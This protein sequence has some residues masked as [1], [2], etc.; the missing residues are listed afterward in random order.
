MSF[1]NLAAWARSNPI[2]VAS[3]VVT[4]A[5]IGVIV[6]TIL[7]AG[8]LR[9]EIEDRDNKFST[10]RQLMS[11]TIEVPSEDP[12]G[13]PQYLRN[14]AISQQ[15]IE[16]MRGIYDRMRQELEKVFERAENIN[17]PDREMLVAGL[18]PDADRTA[19]LPITA[20]FAYRQQVPR[21]L[22]E[23]E[24]QGGGARLDA[25]EPPTAQSV[26]RQIAEDVREFIRQYQGQQTGED[27][28]L[29]S[30][31]R[32]QLEQEIRDRTMQMIRDR[33]ES[34]H[35]YAETDP[36]AEAFPFVMRSSLVNPAPG[37][38]SPSPALLW[39]AQLELW[40]MRD[41]A[42]AIA[43]VN[44]VDNPQA[45][46]TSAPVKR[47]LRVEVLPGYVG[48]HTKGGLAEGFEG[49][50]GR[51]TGEGGALYPYPA[52]PTLDNPDQL[53]DAAFHYTPT[54]R[55]SNALYDVRHA[56][57]RAV[58]DVRQLPEL[59]DAIS[60]ANFMTVLRVEVA[61]VNEFEALRDRYF[62]GTGDCVEVTL[63]IESIWL[64]SWTEPLMPEATKRHLGILEPLQ[65][66]EEQEYD[67]RQG[68]EDPYNGRRPGP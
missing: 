22:Q 44:E 49:R 55:V 67:P 18:F 57:L 51:T 24:G 62:Y 59:L 43:R 13:E 39:E 30:N 42:R 19:D 8:G 15:V 10:T 68:Y 53:L 14:M 36:D 27:V 11:Q 25:G 5:A 16:R 33:A 17:R 7:A 56:Q 12:D 65:P 64:R 58:V 47:L 2:T 6:Y 28:S 38:G 23:P 46:V 32:S 37:A 40:I 66:P 34:I 9:S 48:I 4:V 50:S 3:V 63:L 60:H 20:R 54:G 52:H 45:D 26:E 31:Q 35:L 21:I 1:S 61:D 29:T 41:I